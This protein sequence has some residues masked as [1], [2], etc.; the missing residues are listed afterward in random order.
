[1]QHAQITDR[2]ARDLIVFLSDEDILAVQKDDQAAR[3]LAEA[4]ALLDAFDRELAD[5]DL[6]DVR[7]TR[8]RARLTLLEG[9]PADPVSARRAA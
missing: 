4:D 7:A 8:R 9:V 2:A 6:A 5:D 3:E 1:M